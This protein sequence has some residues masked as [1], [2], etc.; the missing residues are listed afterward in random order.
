MLLL[1]FLIQFLQQR[2][3]SFSHVTSHLEIFV[4][5]QVCKNNPSNVLVWEY[6]ISSSSSRFPSQKKYL[7]WI[8]YS[9]WFFHQ[10]MWP[11]EFVFY[12]MLSQSHYK[13]IFRYRVLYIDIVNLSIRWYTYWL[14]V[15]SLYSLSVEHLD[16][17]CW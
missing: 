13:W 4:L 3:H 8:S 5:W 16:S 14:A 17:I 2:G 6:N 7:S 9:T 10:P 12:Q 1:R 11:V 15:N